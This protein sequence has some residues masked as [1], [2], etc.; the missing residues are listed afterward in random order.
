MIALILKTESYL[1][2]PAHQ[3]L[4]RKC[5]LPS[6]SACGQGGEAPRVEVTGPTQAFE[7]GCVRECDAYAAGTPR[8]QSQRL[9]HLCFLDL[10]LDV[11]A[12]FTGSYVCVKP[13][14][15]EYRLFR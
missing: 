15:H 14:K 11:Q 12:F 8:L 5:L 1:R 2:T 6:V 13:Q 7:H 9:H 3:A 10:I 4:C